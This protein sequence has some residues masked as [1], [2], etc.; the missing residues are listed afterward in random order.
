M[1]SWLSDRG[2]LGVHGR[3]VGAPF[4]L[5]E[6]SRSDNEPRGSGV[7]LC[8]L[9]AGRDVWVGVEDAQDVE[10]VRLLEVEG[11][12]AEPSHRVCPQLRPVEF[13][14]VAGEPILD[15]RAMSVKACLTASMNR[16]AV[17]ASTSLA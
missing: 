6:R 10:V 2:R 3:W 8:V 17:S 13:D 15:C 14:G 4:G 5:A 12:V 9:E 1:T 7:G 16:R 11:E